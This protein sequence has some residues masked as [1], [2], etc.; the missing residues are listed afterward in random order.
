M[1]CLVYSFRKLQCF[2]F[3]FTSDFFFVS[4]PF[5][6]TSTLFTVF[7]SHRGHFLFF[8][9]NFV[10]S[11]ITCFIC[12]VYISLGSLMPGLV[13]LRLFACLCLWARSSLLSLFFVGQMFS[14]LLSFAYCLASV[15][16]PIFLRLFC[17]SCIVSSSV[18]VGLCV[19]L[20]PPVIVVL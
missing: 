14:V 4:R 10:S 13:S 15:G 19:S 3:F 2:H 11:N 12:H 18:S 8:W 1:T 6:V 20:N 7:V 9:H 5:R 17:S 16:L